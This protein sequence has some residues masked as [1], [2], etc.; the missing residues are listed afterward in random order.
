MFEWSEKLKEW[1]HV[2][3]ERENDVEEVLYWELT[4]FLS[5]RDQQRAQQYINITYIVV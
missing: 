2:D 3:K 5:R 4:Q 1:L